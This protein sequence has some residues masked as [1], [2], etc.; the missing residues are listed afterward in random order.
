MGGALGL[1]LGSTIQALFE[2]IGPPS[3]E[4]LVAPDRNVLS[5]Y[6]SLG[7]SEAL[8]TTV[9]GIVTR[10]EWSYPLD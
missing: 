4:E 6:V 3:A 10:I 7:S 8:F 2:T 9:D 5:Y 1:S